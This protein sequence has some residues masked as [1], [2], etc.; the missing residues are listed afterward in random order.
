[1]QRIVCE[2]CLVGRYKKAGKVAYS[3]FIN[4]EFVDPGRSMSSRPLLFEEEGSW[5]EAFIKGEG[6]W[7]GIEE[8][9]FS[10]GEIEEWVE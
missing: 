1:M 5:T 7:M 2:G 4:N 10:I 8:S 6:L 3:I 9:C